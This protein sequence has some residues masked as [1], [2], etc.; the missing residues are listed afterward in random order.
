MP[1][2]AR[3]GGHRRRRRRR[4]ARR[5]RRSTPPPAS[6]T[7]ST[8]TWRRRRACTPSSRA[9]TS[10]ASRCS[11][12]A[13]RARCTPAASPSCSSRPGRLP[14]QRQRAVGVRHAGV[15]GAHRPRPLDG[16]RP[17]TDLDAAERDAAARRAAR[18]GASSALRRRR[19]GVGG[20]LPLRRRCPLRRS[21]QRDHG[22]GR[23]R[24]SSVAGDRPTSVVDAFEAEYRRIYGLT[25]PDVG[26]EAVTWRLS[27]SSA[28]PAFEPGRSPPAR[29]RRAARGTAPVVFGR[30]SAAVETPVYRRADAR[31]RRRASTGPAIVEE[32]ETTV[33]IRPGWRGRGRAPTAARRH[34]SG[35]TRVQD[36][37]ERDD[38]RRV[39]RRRARDPLAD[40]DRHG[41]RAGPGV[42]AGGVQ[43]DRARGGRPR[44]R[45]VRSARPDGRAGRHRHAGPHQLARHRRR[46]HPRRVPDR[47]ARAGRRADHQRPVQDRRPAA[48]RHGA[49][50]VWRNGRVIA[51]FGSTIHHTD[52]GG[53]GIGAGGRD[54][55]KK[56]SGSRSAS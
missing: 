25:I 37:R 17:S 51:F 38:D 4:P 15:A 10:A 11:R 52:V 54:C 48:R 32:R 8:R 26:I 41:Q 46:Q 35:S 44:Q 16:A 33:V 21:G 20:P 7:S 2:D 5:S 43:P 53:Y 50:P 27:A 31:R 34:A 12:S 14:G 13:V 23:R 28:A 9:S 1:L 24:A 47:L 3:G 42:A 6:T 39:R 55:S 56:A 45:R 40:A 29:R 22:V 19:A 18:R 49:V 36:R 30:G